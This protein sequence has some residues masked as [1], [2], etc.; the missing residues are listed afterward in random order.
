MIPV[1]EPEKAVD[2]A[3]TNLPQVIILDVMLPRIDGWELLG[4]FKNHPSLTNIPIVVFSILNQDQMARDLGAMDF[5]KKP[6][7]RDDLLAFLEQNS[8]HFLTQ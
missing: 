4:S 3:L 1:S 5:L 2:A 6:V 7:S 8:H